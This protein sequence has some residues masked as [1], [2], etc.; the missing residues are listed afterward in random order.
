VASLGQ[1]IYSEGT[2]ERTYAALLERAGARLSARQPLVLDATY[3]RRRHREALVDAGRRLGA[4]VVFLECRASRPTLASRL[5][6]R[7]GNSGPSDARREHLDGLL[8][9][10][11]ALSEQP[12]S[13]Y[14][15]VD[16]EGSLEETLLEAFS[17]VYAR[18]ERQSVETR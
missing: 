14:L 9:R 1:G 16:T 3:S 5:E 12:S 4:S 17:G 7:E 15:P 6:G 8:E 11:E 18:Q 13:A 10:F 2:T